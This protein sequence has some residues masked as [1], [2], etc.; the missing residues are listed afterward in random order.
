[1]WN[2]RKKLRR[3]EAACRGYE[4]RLLKIE[5]LHHSGEQ[6]LSMMRRD[7]AKVEDIN[8]A[9]VRENKRLAEIVDADESMMDDLW[10]DYRKMIEE[11]KDFEALRD[12]NY[13]LWVENTL[14]KA[15][16]LKFDPPK[17]A[18]IAGKSRR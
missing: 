17:A 3:Y 13:R 12:E 15:E 9:L 18:A 1:M 10:I 8:D 16:L 2:T 14:L 6:L 7:L 5:H 11:H 4:D